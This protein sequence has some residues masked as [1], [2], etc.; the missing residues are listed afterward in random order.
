MLHESRT[1]PGQQRFLHGGF[2]G[3]ETC[4]MSLGNDLTGWRGGMN[5]I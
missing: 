2:I 5:I 1:R 4:L 3:R